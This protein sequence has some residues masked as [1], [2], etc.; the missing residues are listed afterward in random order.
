M[1]GSSQSPSS[2]IETIPEN[3]FREPIDYL[4]TDHFRQR[5][6]CNFLDEIAFDPGAV[7]A[8]RLADPASGLVGRSREQGRVEHHEQ[9]KSTDPAKSRE[10]QGRGAPHLEQWED[11]AQQRRHRDQKIY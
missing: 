3:L 11:E 1:S 8:A 9:T 4:F 5:V 10:R 2:E 6:V 7:G